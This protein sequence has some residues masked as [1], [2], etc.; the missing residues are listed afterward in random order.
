MS[1]EIKKVQHLVCAGRFGGRNGRA[2][3]PF[4][5]ASGARG[6]GIGPLAR[7]REASKQQHRAP[8]REGGP[9]RRAREKGCSGGALISE[10]VGEGWERRRV[11][12]WRERLEGQWTRDLRE[13]ETSTRG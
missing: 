1:W 11:L 4:M 8:E 10:V 6:S 2:L 13:R 12:R 5:R 7:N 3:H 9:R